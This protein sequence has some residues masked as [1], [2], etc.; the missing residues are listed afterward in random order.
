MLRQLVAG[1]AA[2]A[3]VCGAGYYGR[4]LAVRYRSILVETYE[5]AQNDLNGY[6]AKGLEMIR[7]SV[8]LAITPES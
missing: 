5:N 7:K 6:I 8:D 4:T 3:L 2:L 1:I